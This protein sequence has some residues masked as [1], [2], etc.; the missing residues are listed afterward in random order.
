MHPIYKAI[1]ILYSVRVSELSDNLKVCCCFHTLQFALMHSAAAQLGL[2]AKCSLKI[3][4][5]KIQ[6]LFLIPPLTLQLK[7]P[8][9][10]AS[11]V[12]AHFSLSFLMFKTLEKSAKAVSFSRKFICL[13]HFESQMVV[14]EERKNKIKFSCAESGF[15]HSTQCDFSGISRHT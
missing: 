4:H 5:H 11:L 1:I 14:H 8:G 7:W 6:Y 12:Y 10:E 15:S 9:F 13:C 2:H 3:R